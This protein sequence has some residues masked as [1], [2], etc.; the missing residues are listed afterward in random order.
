MSD[1]KDDDIRKRAYDLWEAA[2]RP[3]GSHEHH[4][5]QAREELQNGKAAPK[6][7]IKGGLLVEEAG[8]KENRQSRKGEDD[9]KGRSCRS[10]SGQDTRPQDTGR[11]GFR[12]VTPR[13]RAERS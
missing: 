5:H 1:I 6:S 12:H 11:D 8:G 13:G 3:D 2:G 4:W 7:R 10:G 9:R